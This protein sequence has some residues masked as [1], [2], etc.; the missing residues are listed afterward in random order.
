MQLIKNRIK[1]P[2]ILQRQTEGVKEGSIVVNNGA[3]NV[4]EVLQRLEKASEPTAIKEE[5]YA[6]VGEGETLKYT[7]LSAGCMAVTVSFE[8][9]GGAGVHIVMLEQG[10][11]QWTGFKEAIAGK[12]AS[13]VYLNCDNWGGRED[14]RIKEGESSPMSTLQLSINTGQYLPD[15]YAEEGDSLLQDGWKYKSE[16]V[17]GWFST[18][19]GVTPE[20][21]GGGVSRIYP[22]EEG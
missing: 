12:T 1:Q 4:L 2:S 16:D 3:G 9:G 8:G 21:K 19:L 15:P 13:K 17:K 5:Q 7:A 11:G 14:W 20:L 18:Q 22:V 10:S 6:I